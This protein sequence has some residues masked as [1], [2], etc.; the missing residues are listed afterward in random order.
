MKH[1]NHP[2]KSL[3]SSLHN[4]ALS[5]NLLKFYENNLHWDIIEHALW[6]FIQFKRSFQL[7]NFECHD[8]V[9]EI[10]KKCIEKQP[11]ATWNS[12]SFFYWCDQIFFLVQIKEKFWSRHERRKRKR[13][14]NVVKCLSMKLKL[15][16]NMIFRHSDCLFLDAFMTCFFAFFDHE[17]FIK[18][19]D[20]T[21]QDTT[22]WKLILLIDH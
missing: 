16:E 18:T 3:Q 14:K 17:V 8:R 6:V 20:E 13:Q 7:I 15:T 4:D 21:Q 2:Q 5:K 9:R 11:R 22:I 10:E 1:L 12:K 19:R